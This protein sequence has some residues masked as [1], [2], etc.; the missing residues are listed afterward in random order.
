MKNN[1]SPAFGDWQNLD[2]DA[3]QAPRYQFISKL[4]FPTTALENPIEILDIGSGSGALLPFLHIK[5]QYMGIDANPAASLAGEKLGRMIVGLTAEEFHPGMMRD[6]IVLNEML[7]Y[8]R[9]PIGLLKKYRSILNP[10]G[11]MIV[12]IYRDGKPRSISGY[13]KSL[14]MPL[15]PQSNAHC[16]AIIEKFL[17]ETDWEVRDHVIQSSDGKMVWDI[18]EI[19]P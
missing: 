19:T 17:E 2:T 9:D 10:R 18:L 1:I 3:Q 6:V 16:M 8:T 4:C 11:K 5:T 15:R 12:S 14:V 7:Y 13:L